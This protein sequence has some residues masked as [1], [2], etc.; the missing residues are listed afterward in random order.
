MREYQCVDCVNFENCLKEYDMEY[1]ELHECSICG[2]FELYFA[3][4]KL[5]ISDE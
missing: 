2:N 5:V 3:D 1:E 4:E